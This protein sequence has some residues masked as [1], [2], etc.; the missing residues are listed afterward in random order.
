MS[1][2][3]FNVYM[4]V[5]FTQVVVKGIVD[6]V[7]L[8]ILVLVSYLGALGV[9]KLATPPIPRALQYLPGAVLTTG[10]LYV[11]AVLLAAGYRYRLSVRLDLQ[12]SREPAKQQQPLQGSST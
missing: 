12:K 11:L 10:G 4:K 2:A 6:L 8:G 3:E 1:M 7:I 9:R 5:L